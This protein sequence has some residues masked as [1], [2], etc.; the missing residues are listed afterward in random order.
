MR[1]RCLDAGVRD[2]V[3]GSSQIVAMSVMVGRAGGGRPERRPH[4]P[5]I[6]SQY[7]PSLNGF[8]FGDK[9]GSHY[10]ESF[11]RF[12]LPRWQAQALL[13]AHGQTIFHTL[14]LA[15][16]RQGRAPLGS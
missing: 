7:S 4:S 15:G 13:T 2:D 3:S 12:S 6:T 16:L 1:A 11:D 5:S 10:G 9:F 14:I 8:L